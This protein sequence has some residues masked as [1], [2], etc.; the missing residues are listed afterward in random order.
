E[1]GE[2]E[3]L[4]LTIRLIED[5]P[6][7]EDGNPN[8]FDEQP[9]TLSVVSPDAT[10]KI[11]FDSEIDRS[12][13]YYAAVPVKGP[14]ERTLEKRPGLVLSLHGA[15]VEAIGQARAYAAKD[16]LVIACPTNRRPYGFDWEDWGRADA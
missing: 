6:A 13:Q 16:D 3:K 5:A 4:Q 8:I 11:T 10:R 7:T 12:V 14:A 15:S 9:L 2:I 1:P